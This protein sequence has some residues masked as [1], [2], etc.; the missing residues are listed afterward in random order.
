MQTPVLVLTY[1]EIKNSTASH[2]AQ[3]PSDELLPPVTGSIP[4]LDIPTRAG[5]E[6]LARLL[7]VPQHRG[8]G[9]ARGVDL[10]LLVQLGRLPVPEVG[11]AG[12]V[13]R[14]EELAVGRDIEA[15][16][17]AARAVAAVDLLAVLAELVRGRVDEHLV[18]GLEGH[19]LG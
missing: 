13:A 18:V 15:D 5:G 7:G 11:E 14:G 4:H 10:E 6:H 19:V 1:Q 3:Q 9:A 17:G 2:T 12:G 8:D 16:G